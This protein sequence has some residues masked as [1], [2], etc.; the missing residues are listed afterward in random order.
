MKKL[1]AWI[2][3]LCMVMS[4][5]CACGGNSN[6]SGKTD[7][8]E[9]NQSVDNR[10]NDRLVAYDENGIKVIVTGINQN[11]NFAEIDILVE[12]NTE[13][14]IAFG[15][16]LFMVNGIT[17]EGITYTEAASGE[18]G[19]GKILFEKELLDEVGIQEI[20]TVSSVYADV[21]DINAYELLF[22]P[23]L[24]FETEIAENYQQKIDDSGEVILQDAGVTVI[25]KPIARNHLGMQ[26][27]LLVIN[28]SGKDIYI[29]SNDVCVNGFATEGSLYDWVPADSVRFCDYQIFVTELEE[30]GIETV[31]E[32]S[33]SVSIQEKSTA[34]VICESGEL[35]F[36]AN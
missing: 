25:Y 2:L 16:T 13:H 30:K 3:M 34:M 19:S 17:I 14:D 23:E 35:T 21:T 10:D 28:D 33:F 5:L 20:A 8:N 31:E 11:E 36:T 7:S 9:K 29:K 27:I 26:F 1:L 24:S 32:L 6:S 15:G 12:N 4:L 22:Y 18:Q